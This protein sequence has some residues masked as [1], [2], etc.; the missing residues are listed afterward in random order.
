MILPIS[1][2]AR[3]PEC[4][5]DRSN[6]LIP[7]SDASFIIDSACS[8][9]TFGLNIDHVPKPTLLQRR[10]LFPKFLYLN[11]GVGVVVGRIDEFIP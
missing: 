8:L 11:P 2:S 7:L 5:S 9:D 1:I 4:A 3:M 10:P 6:R